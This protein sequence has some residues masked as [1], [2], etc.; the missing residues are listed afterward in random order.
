M[1]LVNSNNPDFYSFLFYF[2]VR[3]LRLITSW[4]RTFTWM[5]LWCFSRSM[6][7]ELKRNTWRRP[8]P[9]AG[10]KRRRCESWPEMAAS[11]AGS[12]A[13]SRAGQP[14]YPR[15]FTC[16]PCW[17]NESEWA[18]FKN[19]FLFSH[20]PLKYLQNDMWPW[21]TKPVISVNFLKLRFMHHLKAE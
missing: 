21:T 12:T 20:S 5:L 3:R 4:M 16:D 9:S 13:W 14:H 7:S 2:V 18:N 10:S 6:K 17:Q 15:K 19:E 1:V 8:T 11:P